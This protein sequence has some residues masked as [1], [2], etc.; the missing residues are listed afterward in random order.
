MG[1]LW[2]FRL[3]W[4][5][6]ICY[7]ETITFPK[8][9][10]CP[11]NSPPPPHPYIDVLYIPS[12]R[13]SFLNFPDWKP[14]KWISWGFKVVKTQNR[15]RCATAGGSL[16]HPSLIAPPP[17]GGPSAPRR[18]C[19]FAADT[20]SF[21]TCPWVFSLFLITK[22]IGFKKELFDGILE[23]RFGYISLLQRERKS[24]TSLNR[25]NIAHGAVLSRRPLD[26]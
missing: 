26:I 19:F 4:K 14:F 16:P 11:H 8:H 9:P 6:H 15:R 21:C 3:F 1:E 22:V 13:K 2:I 10:C 17:S 24:I 18:G 5:S 7:T 25:H 23:H 12:R 20:N